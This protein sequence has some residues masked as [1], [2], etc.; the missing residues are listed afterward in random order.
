MII[1]KEKENYNEH[2]KTDISIYETF[3]KDDIINKRLTIFMHK[4]IPWS[5]ELNIISYR[6]KCVAQFLKN[7]WDY[8]DKLKAGE[9]DDGIIRKLEDCFGV[10][11]DTILLG[12][13]G[14][15]FYNSAIFNLVSVQPMNLPISAISIIKYDDNN[16]KS[17]IYTKDN[18]NPLMN[19]H[20]SIDIIERYANDIRI[21]ILDGFKN[22]SNHQNTADTCINTLFE[23]IFR[24]IVS[25]L[26]IACGEPIIVNGDLS[27]EI[28]NQSLSIWNSTMLGPANRII[29]APKFK[30]FVDNTKYKF[31]TDELMPPDRILLA[32]TGASAIISGYIWSPYQIC[33]ESSVNDKIIIR[34][35]DSKFLADNGFYRSLKMKN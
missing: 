1:H 24:H 12:A 3:K 32:Y 11:W 6:D 30:Q 13:L 14:R 34:L 2:K 25:D 28:Y 21:G 19:R 10:N 8:F 9:G 23:D 15:A 33:F 27:E 29:G 26:L 22:C 17:N 5:K 18:E 16:K 4:S 20:I 31:L 35:R 7:E